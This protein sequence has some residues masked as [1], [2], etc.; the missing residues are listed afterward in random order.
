M[1]PNLFYIFIYF[2]VALNSRE[3]GKTFAHLQYIIYIS[4]VLVREENSS[5]FLCVVLSF[6]P[7]IYIKQH[8]LI[9]LVYI[10]GCIYC[11]WVS[12]YIF[13]VIDLA[14]RKVSERNGPRTKKSRLFVIDFLCSICEIAPQRHNDGQF[15]S[16][17]SSLV[18]SLQTQLMKGVLQSLGFFIYF[19]VPHLFW[20]EHFWLKLN[21]YRGY[22]LIIVLKKWLN[23][24]YVFKKDGRANPPLFSLL[25]YFLFLGWLL[26]TSATQIMGSVLMALG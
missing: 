12:V 9:C 11:E 10:L 17:S 22:N 2:Y 24:L 16:L 13:L 4:V 6:A 1:T 8:L 26:L 14:D 23:I 15:R 20:Q 21:W 25:H 5:T 7:Y 19:P 18:S 3:R